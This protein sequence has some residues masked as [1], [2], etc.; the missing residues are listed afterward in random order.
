MCLICSTVVQPAVQ[1]LK[2]FNAMYHLLVL[3]RLAHKEFHEVV[4]CSNY[5]SLR[6]LDCIS[7]GIKCFVLPFFLAK[8][9]TIFQ[10]P[11]ALLIEFLA[12]LATSVYR[13]LRSS[14]RGVLDS[15]S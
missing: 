2:V 5:L 9:E 8:A 15:V 7:H 13:V 14:S 3:L 11:S 12:A 6:Q 10:V 1:Y 4:E